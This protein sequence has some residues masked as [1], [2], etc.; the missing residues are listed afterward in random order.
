MKSSRRKS[1]NSEEASWLR[2]FYQVAH[3]DTRWAKEQGWRAVKW[4]VLLFGAALGIQ[5]YLT[6]NV[7]S[8]VFPLIDIAVL[9]VAI[10]Y[11]RDLHHWMVST[12]RTTDKIE[13]QIHPISS[14]LERHRS[15]H[16]HLSFLVVQ[17]AVIIIAFVLVVLAHCDL[18]P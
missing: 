15:N 10:L 12:S 16:N 14:I 4:T 2:T 1:G 9:S 13:A 7:P 6:S 3:S 11:L 8:I 5:K 17:Y 18:R